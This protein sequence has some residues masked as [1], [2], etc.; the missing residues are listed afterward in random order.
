MTTNDSSNNYVVDEEQSPQS[1]GG[2]RGGGGGLNNSLG[3]EGSSVNFSQ[4]LD[5]QRRLSSER[6]L[7]R[8]TSVRSLRV[9]IAI[10]EDEP[11]DAA[12]QQQHC[13]YASNNN[14]TAPSTRQLS[15]PSF[16]GR[17]TAAPSIR[18]LGLTSMEWEDIFEELGN[19][20]ENGQF[21][22]P[23]AHMKPFYA[24]PVQ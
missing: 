11:L 5:A 18:G 7:H 3:G 24:P 21:H 4:Y 6:F 23:N 13:R 15:L 9:P 20:D 14:I 17:S 16:R 1:P 8:R 19:I 22:D 12:E 2:R 10:S